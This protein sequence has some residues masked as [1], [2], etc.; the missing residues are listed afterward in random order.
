[1]FMVPLN[2]NAQ[3]GFLELDEVLRNKINAQIPTNSSVGAIK[4]R[5]LDEKK[6]IFVKFVD[7]SGNVSDKIFNSQGEIILEKALPI[8]HQSI[9]AE[10]LQRI[11]DSKPI[12]L[13][14]ISNDTVI[15]V[16]IALKIKN[17]SVNE[18]IEFGTATFENGNCSVTNN[19]KRVT[20]KEIKV[21][22]EKKF[23]RIASQRDVRVKQRQIMLQ[24]LAAR[25]D[26]EEHH[27]M[28]KAIKQGR[29]SVTLPMKKGDIRAFI[30]KNKDIITGIE[31]YVK[32]QVCLDDAM[33]STEIDPYALDYSNRKGNGIGIYMSELNCPDCDHI[34]NYYKISGSSH[35]HCEIVS[36]II[37]G[38]SPDSFIYCRD[39]C[40]LPTSTDLNGYDGNPRV[41][42]ENHSWHGDKMLYGSYS[43]SDKLH[44]DHVYDNAVALFVAAGNEGYQLWNA[45]VT[46]PAKAL[47]SITVGNYDDSTNK[48]YGGSS[49]IN[50]Y[51]GNEKPEICAPATD[52]VVGDH[53]PF[54]ATSFASPHAAGFAADLMSAYS[55]LK[56]RPYYIK[57]L[58]LAGA[59]NNISGGVD[60]VGLG[61][62]NFYRT[63]YNGT[64]TSW[65]GGNDSF[66]YF[67]SIDPYPNNGLIDDEV[68]LSSSYSNV[69]VVL[70]WLN[71]GTYTYEH[72]SDA[73]SIGM[74][75]DISIYDPDGD[76][77]ANSISQDN[78]Y[79]F[80]SFDPSK[81]GTYRIKIERHVNRDTSSKLHM[82]LVINW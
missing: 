45:Y 34:T 41:Y 17:E 52:I 80:I 4:T 8:V 39:G 43:I 12:D 28:K 1:M 2:L 79:E 20:E 35:Y 29:S 14:Y 56:L 15:K 25:N 21:N 74:D 70:C 63:H 10:N 77:I 47:N 72:R 33:L 31:L 59:D 19:G 13:N 22:Q 9:I 67:D 54:S 55:W 23:R 64:C 66:S 32:P 71:R 81:T 57:A 62:I 30:Q 69:R 49:Y 38:V 27:A 18:V 51:T 82:G 7:K 5:L 58:M 50:P 36:E 76:F 46:T 60:K 44:D 68:Y 53:S 78:P 3:G 73:H 48:I 26:F 11:L 24:T 6:F 75:M 42:I 61:G 40:S 16:V 65:E 37:R